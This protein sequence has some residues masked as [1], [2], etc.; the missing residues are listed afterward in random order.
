MAKAWGIFSSGNLCV[1]I[2]LRSTRLDAM[3]LTGG[4]DRTVMEYKGYHAAV[5]YDQEA[6][7][8]QGE[9]VGPR[10]V[11]FFEGASVEELNKE[12]RFSIDDYLAMCAQR[13]Q[14]P[15]KPFS[16]KIPLRVSPAVHWAATVA[17]RTEGKSL[18]AWI[19]ATVE[20][21]AGDSA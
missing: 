19:A 9:I 21:A 8:F 7:V 10:D 6:R 4:W 14:A 3:R 12:F 17:A 18:N 11:I 15:D 13:G 16:G 20:R 5:T 1:T 2:G